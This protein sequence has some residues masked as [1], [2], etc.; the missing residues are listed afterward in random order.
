M[1]IR[2]LLLALLPLV[3]LS[4]DPKPVE[5]GDKPDP[6][7]PVE[8]PDPEPEPEPEPEIHIDPVA[9]SFVEKGKN[10][11]TMSYD[12]ASGVY[13]L[14]TTGTD[15][16]IY[17]GA[18]AADLDE[19][20]RILSFDYLCGSGV[21]LFQVFY[22]KAIAENR[23]RHF[24]R[25]PATGGENWKNYNC[26]IASDRVSFNWGHAGDNLRLDFGTKKG[27]TIRI[28][29]F[30]VREM[31]ED[32]LKA[33]QEEI[34]KAQGKEAEAARIGDYVT[35][36]YPCRITSFVVGAN[37]VTV[38]AQTDGN[39]EYW[40]ADIAPWESITEATTFSLCG[41]S[42]GGSPQSVTLSRYVSRDGLPAYDRLLSRFA[43]VK[44]E[45]DKQTLCSHARYAD[46]ISGPYSQPVTPKSKK[47]LGGFVVNE[48]V[49]DLDELGIGSVTVNIV[50][51]SVV[52][53]VKSG[54]YN[55][56]HKYGGKTYYMD[57]GYT[58][59][60]DKIMAECRKRGIVVS[61]ILLNRHSDTNSSATP[62]MKHPENDGGNYSMPNLTTPNGV[63]VYGAVLD[64]LAD[65]YSNDTYG[66]IH[67]W[68][69]HNE[70]DAQ[71]EWTN[72]G[73]QPE[74]R[75]MDAYVKS[76]RMCHNIAHQYDSQASVLISLTHSWA[77]AEGQYASRS[78]LED[79]CKFSSAE[80]D[81]LWAS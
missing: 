9:L 16:F 25:I 33:Y 31:N 37:T 78:M 21:D 14:S 6:E 55:V 58:S 8:N 2:H 34:A 41:G 30:Q 19:K 11:I 80:G 18:L 28:K 36:S 20:H 47:G 64:Y 53:T 65:R 50:L 44:V 39:G 79:L 61:A 57:K 22:G 26:S 67:H 35:R 7:N 71:K 56:E 27:V 23:S 29:N 68:I 42:D 60:L 48:N 69:L 12:A 4:C 77:K 52:N 3:I 66:R 1:R 13:T 17:A 74:W 40:F 51:N 62:I 38:K 15:P 24:G 81:F 72:M 76:M 75:Y 59:Q 63:N 73:D 32:E 49:S 70:V 46:E 10:D 45:G 43:I 5:E 54:N